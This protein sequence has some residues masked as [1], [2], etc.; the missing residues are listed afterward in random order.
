MQPHSR[1]RI[2]WLG[3]ALLAIAIAIA[4]VVVAFGRNETRHVRIATG[5]RGGTFLPLG[6]T[7]ARGLAHDLPGVSFEALESPGGSASVEMLESHRAEIALISN[8]VAGSS[9]IRLIAPLY[10]ETLQIVV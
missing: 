6:Q 9:A 5:T 7:L 4:I 2:A 8:H 3:V 10:E 1:R